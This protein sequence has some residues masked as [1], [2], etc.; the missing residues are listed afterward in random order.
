MRLTLYF[1]P[2]VNFNGPVNFAYTATDNSGADDPTPA[3]ATINVA[4]VNDP[5]VAKSDTDAAT[6]GGVTTGNVLT[7]IDPDGPDSKLILQTDTQGD[8]PSIIR[9]ITHDGIT[10]ALN[11]AKTAVSVSGSPTPAAGSWAYSDATGDLTITT[12]LG[13]TLKIN[14][15]G[16]NPGQYTYTA[17]GERALGFSRQ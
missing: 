9:S 17:L 14:L 16:A 3:T 2:A 13:G 12:E 15:D 11:A 4:S 8:G 6:T 10:Y 5:I 1:K 7:G